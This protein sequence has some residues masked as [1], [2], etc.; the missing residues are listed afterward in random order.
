MPSAFSRRRSRPGALSF[1]NSSTAPIPS[2]HA[3]PRASPHLSTT[4]SLPLTTSSAITAT[5]TITSLTSSLRT[6]TRLVRKSLLFSA[7]ATLSPPKTFQDRINKIKRSAAA[8]QSDRNKSTRETKPPLELPTPPDTPSYTP[9]SYTAPSYTVNTTTDDPPPSP[10]LSPPTSPLSHALDPAELSYDDGEPEQT[11]SIA[12]DR[13]DTSQRGDTSRRPSHASLQSNNLQSSHLNGHL[14]D[15]LKDSLL[16][17]RHQTAPLSL[18]PS[19]YSAH[20]P[21]THTSTL[22]THVHPPPPPPASL[23]TLNAADANRSFKA[24]RNSLIK[25]LSGL[26]SQI[27]FLEQK[28]TIANAKY[29]DLS[30]SHRSQIDVIRSEMSLLVSDNNLLR[31]Q[32]E[33]D[34]GMILSL[35]RQVTFGGAEENRLRHLASSKNLKSQKTSA[36]TAKTAREKLT[37]ATLEKNRSDARGDELAARIVDLKRT[38]TTREG[39]LLSTIEEREHEIE[40]LKAENKSVSQAHVS[41]SGRCEDN[42]Q[43][44]EGMIKEV[45]EHKETERVMQRMKDHDEAEIERL[46]HRLDQEA[47]AKAREFKEWKERCFKAETDNY[48]NSMNVTAREKELDRLRDRLATAIGDAEGEVNVSRAEAEA[49]K[50]RC[51]SLEEQN[52]A[53]VDRYREAEQI[54]RREGVR[55]DGTMKRLVTEMR[56]KSSLSNSFLEERYLLNKQWEK[57]EKEIVAALKREARRVELKEEEAG[58]LRDELAATKTRMAKMEEDPGRPQG[59]QRFFGSS[60]ANLALPAGPELPSVLEAKTKKLERE[61]STLRKENERLMDG[62][63]DARNGNSPSMSAYKNADLGEDVDESNDS[64]VSVSVNEDE[65]SEQ[66]TSTAAEAT[67]LYKEF[68]KDGTVRMASEVRYMVSESGKLLRRIEEYEQLKKAATPGGDSVATSEFKSPYLFE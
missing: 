36:N 54:L 50:E 51:I 57:R 67:T 55:F 6:I 24:E 65:Q 30:A 64:C 49:L 37:K 2:P 17:T 11:P 42:L 62:M 59:Y 18:P 53:L 38:F 61:N 29:R 63:L 8:V 10:P 34:A 39:A 16:S 1:A 46:N 12:T 23:T 20:R 47:N 35:T 32:H 9:S 25:D 7:W 58:R 44:N 31:T 45:N 26:W 15:P 41:A 43:K 56:D 66:S 27:D 4:T 13:G 48:K 33:S 5:V 40:L 3:S 28:L 22:L 21:H 60:S 19:G 14:E 68:K 52:E